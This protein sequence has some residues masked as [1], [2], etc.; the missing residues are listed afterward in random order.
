MK[1]L[2][3][4]LLLLLC[5]FSVSSY[6]FLECQS[7]DQETVK[8]A[9]SLYHK[10]E[11]FRREGVVRKS[12]ALRAK[13]FF[14]EAQACSQAISTQEFCNRSLPSLREMVAMDET[15]LGMS[16]PTERR[17]AITLLAEAKLLCNVR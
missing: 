14:H 4:H 13:V 2:K 3:F 9:E 12:E 16:S 6:A 5:G 10:M 1:F 17:E 11:K 15:E 8:K 7:G